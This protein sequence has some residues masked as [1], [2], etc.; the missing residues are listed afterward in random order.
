MEYSVVINNFDGEVYLLTFRD[1][2]DLLSEQ[3]D[4][5]NDLGK[6]PPNISTIICGVILLTLYY[7]LVLTNNQRQ[8]LSARL[9]IRLWAFP[10]Y[11]KFQIQEV[12]HGLSGS[13]N[14]LETFSV[15]EK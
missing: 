3:C 10:V 6:F 14:P 2:H 1:N 11:P 5:K 15:F 13:H 7:E 12:N 9:T 8:K 4:V